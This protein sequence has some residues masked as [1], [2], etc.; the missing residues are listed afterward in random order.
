MHRPHGTRQPANET[1]RRHRAV[2]TGTIVGT[3]APGLTPT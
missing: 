1:G 2:S 3:A